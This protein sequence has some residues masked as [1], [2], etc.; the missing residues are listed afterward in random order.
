[1]APAEMCHKLEAVKG[2]LRSWSPDALLPGFI[3]SAAP[4]SLRRTIL[5]KE[6]VTPLVHV[7]APINADGRR[8]M[9]CQVMQCHIL[10][11]WCDQE[12][13]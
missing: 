11:E 12:S 9:Y 13:E 8:H 4:T 7:P 3:L 6:S 5:A 10:E 1:M 2:A